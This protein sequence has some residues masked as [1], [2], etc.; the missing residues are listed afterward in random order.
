MRRLIVLGVALGLAAV[1]ATASPIP[2][3]FARITVDEGC[4]VRVVKGPYK[5]MV[6]GRTELPTGTYRIVVRP[7]TCKP[8][9][10]TITVHRGKLVKARVVSSVP[11]TPAPTPSPTPTATSPVEPT[12]IDTPTESP[13]P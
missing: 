1:P 13:S 12:P 5:K 6:S 4:L 8:S 7:K 11:A 9:K 10:R 2:T 3:G